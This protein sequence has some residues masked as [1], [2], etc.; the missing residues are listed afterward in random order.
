MQIY[1]CEYVSQFSFPYLFYL[2]LFPFLFY[3][4]MQIVKFS[5]Y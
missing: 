1:M 3:Q 2:I 4:R 5:I